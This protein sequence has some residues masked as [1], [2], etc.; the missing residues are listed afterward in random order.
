LSETET[1]ESVDVKEGKIII[2]T[3]KETYS[4]N[5]DSAS[6]EK[7]VKENDEETPVLKRIVEFNGEKLTVTSHLKKLK[8]DEDFINAINEETGEE[9]GDKLLDS[10]IRQLYNLSELEDQNAIIQALDQLNNINDPII[11]VLFLYA[12]ELYN[13]LFIN[14][15]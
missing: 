2:K 15:K 5:K 4:Y 6:L 9:N 10:F 13:E 1:L 7:N 3:N 12:E 8:K 14:C 11:S